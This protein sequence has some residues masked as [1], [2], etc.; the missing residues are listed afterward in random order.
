MERYADLEGRVRFNASRVHVALPLGRRH[1]ELDENR[2]LSA[3]DG[4]PWLAGR[5][6]EF[7]GG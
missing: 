2:F 5:R 7:G 3:I 6:V 1:R 4:V